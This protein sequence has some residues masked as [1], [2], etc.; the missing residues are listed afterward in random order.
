MRI[1]P[2][3]AGT[4]SEPSPLSSSGPARSVPRAGRNGEAGDAGGAPDEPVV[5]DGAGVPDL[6]AARAA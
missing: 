2:G 1:T 6:V 4:F 3:P 5:V